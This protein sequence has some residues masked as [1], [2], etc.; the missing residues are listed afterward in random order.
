M[1]RK[2][3]KDYLK[4]Q[5]EIDPSKDIEIDELLEYLNNAKSKGATHVDLYAYDEGE[6][7]IQ[8]HIRCVES[9][10]DYT[11]R[12]NKH[13]EELKYK[14]VVQLEREKKQYEILKLK[15]ENK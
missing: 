1:E 3:T 9:D 7:D 13:L 12:V 5:K 11:D 14:E 6:V 15:F 10:E 4:D 2:I 8:P